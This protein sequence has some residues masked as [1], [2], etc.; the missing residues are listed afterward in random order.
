MRT[1]NSIC[2]PVEPPLPWRDYARMGEEELAAQDIA[3]VN[4]ACGEGLPES[5]GVD[6]VSSLV[7]LDFWS[8]SV[9]RFTNTALPR[10]QRKRHE[11]N[12]SEAYFRVLCLVTHLQ[13]DLGVHYNP[14]K[15]SEDALLR[16]RRL[17]VRRTPRRRGDLRDSAGPVCGGGS[18]SWLFGE[19]GERLRRTQGQPQFRPLGRGRSRAVQRRG[20]RDGI[21]LPA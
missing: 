6:P 16:S 18:P 21:D 3:R 10:F 17:P 20:F 7:R 2:Q 14:E 12:D 5:E 15:V 11:F 4:L 13:R 8:R 9:D 1:A 19:A